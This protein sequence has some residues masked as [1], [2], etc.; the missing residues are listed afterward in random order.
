MSGLPLIPVNRAEYFVPHSPASVCWDPA[1]WIKDTHRPPNATCLSPRHASILSLSPGTCFCFH[2]P[3]DA[4]LLDERDLLLPQALLSPG[5]G[6]VYL[7]NHILWNGQST[8]ACSLLWLWEHFLQTCTRALSV[9]GSGIYVGLFSYY[10]DLQT[11]FFRVLGF[12]VCGEEMWASD[13][14]PGHPFFPLHLSTLRS[15]TFTCFIFG[16][17]LGKEKFCYKYI[18]TR[19]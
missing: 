19:T 7:K 2:L 6:T 4:E 18:H 9:H 14:L 15:S 11:W 8:V 16:D 5:P 1:H 13:K 10:R 17:F 12:Y 3:F